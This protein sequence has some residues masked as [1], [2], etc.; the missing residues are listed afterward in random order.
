MEE[1]LANLSLLDEEEEALQEKGVVMER[2]Y[3]F[4]LVGCFLTD[5]VVHF[6][7]LCN[8]MTNL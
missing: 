7:S 1:E 6:P 4:Y 8:T 2:S 5:S 3:Q